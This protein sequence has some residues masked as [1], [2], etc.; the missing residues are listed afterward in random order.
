MELPDCH[1]PIT[2]L[3]FMVALKSSLM[4]SSL[5]ST[6]SSVVSFIREAP[7]V[8]QRNTVKPIFSD[9]SYVLRPRLTFRSLNCTQVLQFLIRHFFFSRKLLSACQRKYNSC[10]KAVPVIDLTSYIQFLRPSPTF[11]SM[12][13]SPSLLFLEN[14]LQFAKEIQLVQ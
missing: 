9:W 5:H 7:S 14:L 13:S 3:L 8:C 4:C 1:Y 6:P 2:S 12:Q 10:N 11:P